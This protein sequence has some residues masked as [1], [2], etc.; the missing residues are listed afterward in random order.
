MILWGLAGLVLNSF[1]DG[2]IPTILL[3]GG[4]A[5]LITGLARWKRFGENPEKDERTRRI[6]AWGLSYSWIASLFFMMAL[7]WLDY[8]R[9]VTLTAGTAIGASVIFMTLSAVVF[10]MA[11]SRKGDIE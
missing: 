3:A 2:I 5:F 8:L 6:G 9:V 11:L 10:Q 4:L 7:F 1:G